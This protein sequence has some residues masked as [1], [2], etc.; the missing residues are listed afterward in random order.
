M[1]ARITD[2]FDGQRLPATF[3]ER[4]TYFPQTGRVRIND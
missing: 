4:V 2:P 1:T 3:I